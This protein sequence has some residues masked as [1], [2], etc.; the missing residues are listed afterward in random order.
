MDIQKEFTDFA[1][2]SGWC[3]DGESTQNGFLFYNAQTNDRWI[4]WQAAQIPVAPESFEQAYSEIFSP[5]VK[6]PYPRLENGDYKYIEIDQGWKLWQAA[7]A[8][9]APEQ[10]LTSDCMINKLWFMKGTPVA[11]LI[12]HA[13]EVYKAEVIAQ[14]SKIKFGTDDN[15]VWWA[16]DVPYYGEVQMNWIKEDQEWDI[17]FNEC[18]QGPFDS[19]QECI[20]HLEEC[21]A[22][23]RAEAQEPAND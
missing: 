1:V 2:N 12:K 14:N 11:N 4:G 22:E 15:E 10:T 7:T 20:K 19:K 23:Q 13:E 8:Q 16:H 21:I 17:F 5:I 6:R 9:A 3:V 18:W